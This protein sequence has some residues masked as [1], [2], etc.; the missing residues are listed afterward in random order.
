MD[1]TNPKLPDLDTANYAPWYF[2]LEN[3]ATAIE[4][5]YDLDGN[6]TPPLQERKL[7]TINKIRSKLH[8]AVPSSIPSEILGLL[9]GPGGI[10]TPHNLVPKITNHINQS[11]KGDHKYLKKETKNTLHFRDT[12]IGE[13]NTAHIDNR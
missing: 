3:Y 7:K 5:A 2:A 6:S 8:S 9:I 11:T 13:H 10:P 1:N 4:A 12:H